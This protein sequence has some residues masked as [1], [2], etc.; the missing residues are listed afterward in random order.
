MKRILKWAVLALLVVAVAGVGREPLFWKRYFSALVQPSDLPLSFY[1]PRELISGGNEPPAPRVA[2]ELE[3][4]DSKALEAAAS[5]AGERASRALIVSRHGH[6]VFERYW[7]G[8]GFDTIEDSQSFAQVLAALVTG[9]AIADR[10]IGWPDEPIGNFISEWRNDPRGAITVRNLLQMS[11]GLSPPGSTLNPWGSGAH[12]LFGTDI[13]AE[14]LKRPLSGTPGATWMDQRADP[15]LLALIIE[16]AS[17]QR[18]ATYLSQA[19][20]KRIGAGDAAAW[21]DRPGGA[22]HAD[23]CL[24]ARQGDWIRV[25]ELLLKDGNYRGDELIR[26]G[27][28]AQMLVPAKGNSNYGSY[29]RL[30]ASNVAGMEP[31]ATNDVFLVEGKGGNRMWLIPSLQIAILR[32]GRMPRSPSDWD[33]AHIP[34]LIIRGTRDYLPPQARPGS[35]LSNLVP[36]H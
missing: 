8:T 33:D 21:L 24:L 31:Y 1:E 18:Y 35:D 16:R 25:A 2:P 22:A 32:T 27:W 36:N 29:V 11:S 9:I 19:L 7:S 28:V 23:C 10:K 6:I 13:I 15:Q 26:P 12:E 5:Y 20:W 17:G 4:L 3:S 30:G 14:H 34:N